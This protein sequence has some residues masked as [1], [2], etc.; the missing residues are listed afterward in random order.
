MRKT[1]GIILLILP[2]MLFGDRETMG[3]LGVSTQNLSEAMKI[4]LGVPNGV[5]V[6]KV[7]DDTPAEE[8]GI[9][10]GDVITRINNIEITGYKVLKEIVKGKPN[11]RVAVMIHRKGKKVSTTVT[12]GEREESKMNLE[13]DIPDISDLKTLLSTEELQ[14]NIDDIRDQLEQLKEEIQQLRKQLK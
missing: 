3:Y 4:A 5:L 6:E 1:V 2:L 11:E 13:V 8:G 9:E 10:V 14:K 12:L 7:H